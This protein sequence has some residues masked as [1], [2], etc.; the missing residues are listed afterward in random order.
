MELSLTTL[1]V[2][3]AGNQAEASNTTSG[4][5]TRSCLSDQPTL[6]VPDTATEILPR[7][8]SVATLQ[9]YDPPRSF[10][11]GRGRGGQGS[12]TNR[13]PNYQ[14]NFPPLNPQDQSNYKRFYIIKP[15]NPEI[16]IWKEVDTIKANRELERILKGPPKRITE[17]LNGTLLIEVANFTQSQKIVQI[18]KLDNTD[19]E[20]VEHNSLNFT[21]GTIRS[22]RYAELD[23]DILLDELSKYGVT[24]IYKIKK[25]SGDS[26][27]NT[28]TIILTFDRCELPPSVKISWISLDVRRYIPNPRQCYKCQKYNHSSR[29][30]RAEES[31]CNRCGES[32]HIGNQC[33]NPP[34]C[35]NCDEPHKASDRQCFFYLLEKE[36][37][38]TQT[39]QKIGYKEAKKIVLQR[40]A[41]PK[42]TYSDI[43]K[44]KIS[45]K[46]NIRP[47]PSTSKNNPNPKRSLPSDSEDP[48][49]TRKTANIS[50]DEGKDQPRSLT[51]PPPP[52]P[53]SPHPPSDPI[54]EPEKPGPT[55]AVSESPM[56]TGNVSSS[57]NKPEEKNQPLKIQKT[58][59][60]KTN[61]ISTSQP[62]R[63]IPS[64]GH[65]RELS[66]S[67]SRDRSRI[68]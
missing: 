30:C 24:E 52:P 43:L 19:V 31:I 22:E 23:D 3:S 20:T 58:H 67:S 40:Q 21:K 62:L 16:N 60:G 13:R 46:Q 15:R 49:P 36:I 29:T 5:E 4:I 25:R 28:G 41:E 63:T 39:L 1:P 12:R 45:K 7:P 59:K 47:S 37:I 17:L 42:A 65:P 57:K 61:P 51:S 56:E 66:R 53:P 18:N 34:N 6:T 9:P 68:N 55:V 10:G 14:I 26:L 48:P 64:L 2:A 54:T 35:A 44:S 11:R 27:I 33:N 32:G 8:N 50:T 38:S